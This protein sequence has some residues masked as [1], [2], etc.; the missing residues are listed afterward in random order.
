M[1]AKACEKFWADTMFF[2]DEEGFSPPS[3]LLREH[4]LAQIRHLKFI[5]SQRLLQSRKTG[6]YRIKEWDGFGHGLP[7]DPDAYRDEA[8]FTFKRLS[9][10]Y[11]W[12][13]SGTYRSSDEGKPLSFGVVRSIPE[14]V[15]AP[16]RPLW[17]RFVDKDATVRD[18]LEVPIT[19]K[20][21]RF[22]LPN[23]A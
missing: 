7:I 14:S 12:A 6:G 9:S 5:T 22:Q 20:E 1:H 19:G 11:W 21:L 23:S 3:T 13:P 17:M 10:G 16:N 4:D 2:I 18:M 15:L 8:L